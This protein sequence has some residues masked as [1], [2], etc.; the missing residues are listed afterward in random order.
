MW[1]SIRQSGNRRSNAR[2]LW[3]A[4]KVMACAL[5]CTR[6]DITD[7]QRTTSA[8][9]LA[10]QRAAEYHRNCID[11]NAEA[12]DLTVSMSCKVVIHPPITETRRAWKRAARFHEP[13]QYL[14]CNKDI[15][16]AIEMLRATPAEATGSSYSI[17]IEMILDGGSG[18][19]HLTG[20]NIVPMTGLRSMVKTAVGCSFF[21]RSRRALASVS[22]GA[23][24][25]FFSVAMPPRIYRRK[26]S[27][28]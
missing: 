18:L 27:L 23:V 7:A 28:R 26:V 10:E 5:A 4:A 25:V 3:L 9:V 15:V 8:I 2:P 13:K 20:S 19:S 24:K 6:R 12:H 11:A 14:A 1:P 21:Q 17:V 22:V 16:R